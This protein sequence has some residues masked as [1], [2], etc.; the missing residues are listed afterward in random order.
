MP[1]SADY[2]RVELVAGEEPEPSP[3]PDSDTPFRILL[4]GDFSGRAG[5]GLE[6]ASLQGRRPIFVD[7]DNFEQV[8]E[9][10]GVSLPCLTFA[11][12]DDFHPDR[13]YRQLPVFSGLRRLRERL[14]DRAT[15]AAAAAEMR[16]WST[17]EKPQPEKPAPAPDLARLAP[18][19]LFSRMLD[20]AAPSDAPVPQAP[21]PFDL[22]LRDIVTPHLEPK[23]D[24]RQPELLAQVDDTVSEQMRAILHHPDFQAVEAAWRALFFLVRRM[25]TD[26]GLK[27]YILDVSKDELAPLSGAGS[28]AETP[29]YGIVVEQ[30][31]GTPG[32]EPWAVLAGNYTFGNSAEDVLLVRALGRVARAA[33]APF[34]AAAGPRVLGCAGFGGELEPRSWKPDPQADAAWQALRRS[35]EAEWVGLALPRF[36]LRLPYGSDTDSTEAFDFEEMPGKP[37]HEDYL[38]GNPVFACLEVMSRGF[39]HSAW[40]F[41]PDAFPD[42]EGLPAHIYKEKGESVL[43]PC[44]EALLTERA[45][46]AITDKGLMAWLSM[47][48]GDRIRLLRFQSIADPA[49]ALPGRWR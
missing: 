27:L 14:E 4:M 11:E 22:L 16:A 48:G 30:S 18:D 10:L 3:L 40:E 49:T 20:E 34:M 15:F 33:G 42:I 1:R 38:W 47:K 17:P 26:T 29:L 32:A 36:L 37:V 24:P 31:V 2:A 45:I 13:L 41:R 43:K 44:A 5:Q 35:A 6:D 39:S 28:L 12:L 9:K 19:Q 21:D 25:E 8:M 23:A 46:E 7:R